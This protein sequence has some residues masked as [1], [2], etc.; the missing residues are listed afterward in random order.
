MS[1]LKKYS[2]RKLDNT[3]AYK[4]PKDV[5]DF[6]WAEIPLVTSQQRWRNQNGGRS[7]LSEVISRVKMRLYR[8][9]KKDLWSTFG[10]HSIH[11]K[12]NC[13]IFGFTCPLIVWIWIWIKDHHTFFH[14]HGREGTNELSTIIPF[15]GTWPWASNVDVVQGIWVKIGKIIT[16]VIMRGP[17]QRY[18]LMT[19]IWGRMVE[20]ITSYNHC[21]N[22]W[23]G[24]Y[25]HPFSP[26]SP[27]PRPNVN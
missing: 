6:R 16:Y 10:I 2:C 9:K 5:F 19:K 27:A 13:S 22:C 12:Q 18:S 15:T 14:S 3:R 11:I 23:E 26:S 24:Y 17:H 21:Q 25:F 4:G 1:K 20:Y 7:E 8:K